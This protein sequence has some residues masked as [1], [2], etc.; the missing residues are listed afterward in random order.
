VQVG[1]LT[2]PDERSLPRELEV[3]L[4]RGDPPVYVGFG[5]TGEVDADATRAS[6][7]MRSGSR[8]VAA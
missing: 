3:F 4:D 2:P 6:L 5:S 1:Y 8:G 7:S